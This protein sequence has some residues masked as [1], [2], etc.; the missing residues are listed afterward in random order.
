MT[1]PHLHLLGG[2]DFNGV[3]ATAPAF[4]RKARGMVAYLALQAGQ[5]QSREKL[6]ALLWS[7]NGEA[8]ARMSLRQAVSSVRK[9]IS[10]AGGGR[11]LTDG[12]NL[13]L[14]LDDIDFDVARFE[15]LAAGPAPED[16]EQA[17]ALYRGD[18]LDGLGLREEPFEEWLRVE[19]E[20]LRAIA[21]A[22]LDRLIN[23][24]TTA[25]DPAACIRAAMRLL[26]MEPLR[27]DAHRALMRSY[28][29]QGRVNLALKQYE[30][31]RDALQRE[32]RL[33]PEA[34][35]RHLH[36]ELRARRIASPARPSASS[37][38]PESARPPT[39]YVKS[40]GVNIAYQVTGDGPIDL[41][42]VPGWVSNLD[43]AWASP[44][45]AHVLKRLGSFSR[46]IRI[47][48]RGTG[49]SDRNVGL[50]TLEQRMEDVRAVLDDVGSDRPVLF[51]SSEGG[52]MC[53]LFAATYP[54]RTAA[55]VLTGAYARGTW[56]KDYPWARTVDEVQQDIDT[57]ERQW[58]EPADMRNAA[59]S[60]IEN[61]VER[62]W[63]AAYLRNSA[64]PAD[65]IALWRWGTEI[66]VRDI[67]P[68][69]HVPTLVLQRTGDRWVKPEEGRYLATHIEGARYVELAGRDH[70]IWGEDCDGLIDQIR[71]FVIGALPP[72]RAEKVLISVLA[73]AIDGVAD[74]AKA[75]GQADI[76]R[77]GL[78][79]GGGSE[80]RRS[81]DT[82]LAAFQRPTRSIEC[83]MAIANRLGPCG[84]KV[85]AAIHIGECEARGEDFSGIAIEVTARLLDHAK[86]G[87]IIA[88]RTMR[89][90]VVGSGLTF[91]EQGEMKASG[92][93]GALQYFAVTWAPPGL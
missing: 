92:L 26:A 62:E 40:S 6:A 24:Y 55:L 46:L 69:I 50:P 83:A 89:D 19:R 91:E 14:H 25:A 31:C 67:L 28:A 1:A 65:A 80:I 59:P 11:F 57:V 7:L 74:D 21:V 22:A 13:A 85:R 20:R 73:L 77:D 43:L 3:G 52:P 2:F 32:L 86:P 64:S 71:D 36:D 88:S 8:Q 58:G 66:D 18:L 27:E 56:S 53:L 38:E 5:A 60:L 47:D 72:A 17:A 82:L 75:A 51:G 44:R 79:L 61:M 54:E 48:K 87:Q 23:H 33:M 90:L 4:S 78:L 15:A 63:F 16:L 39:H 81:R 49:L 76:V 93:P 30:V 42:Y 34:E 9:A 12:A 41:V 29:A 68:A 84:L 37:P 70:V 35:T 45:F 10:V